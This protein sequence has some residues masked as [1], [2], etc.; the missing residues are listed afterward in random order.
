MALTRLAE[1]GHL[2]VVPPRARAALE[3]EL[4]RV[5]VAQ[6]VLFHRFESL[7]RLLRGAGVEFLVHKGGALAPLVYA[8]PE[9]RPMVDIDVVI[10]PGDW[11]RVRDTL[12]PAGYRL[13]EG[14]LQAFWLENYFNLSVRS[15]EDPASHF[16]LHWS[17]TQEG[18]YH[19]DTE[20]L[21]PRAQPYRLGDLS[22]LRLGNED[23]LLSLFLH[24]A[25][26]Y[27]EA[28]LIWLY[29]MKQVVERL[30]IDW[31]RLLARAAEWRLMTVVALNIVYLEKVFPGVVPANVRTRAR[32]GLPRRL[33]LAPWRSSAPR[34]LFRAEENRLNQF[35][36]GL[37]AIDRPSDAARFAAGK[38][39]RSLKWAGRRPSRR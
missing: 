38:A 27:F 20:T 31:D 39:F 6:A 4:N 33:L 32:S 22:L 9:D 7:A 23:L 13:P 8:R 25:Y 36:I 10:R 30:A 19:I 1:S 3:S 12:V 2:T 17:L 15:P 14:A 16:D 29:D 34:H 5:R 21:F 37:L 35:V 18:R 11:Q 24:L 26:H 28:R